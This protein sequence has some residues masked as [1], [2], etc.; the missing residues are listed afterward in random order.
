M[1]GEKYILQTSLYDKLLKKKKAMQ[2][3]YISCGTVALKI[4]KT[5]FSKNENG[6]MLLETLNYSKTDIPLPIDILKISQSDK[7]VENATYN[8]SNLNLSVG[9]HRGENLDSHR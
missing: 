4:L 1:K 9:K 3:D 7:F 6:T 8:I 2:S 5:L